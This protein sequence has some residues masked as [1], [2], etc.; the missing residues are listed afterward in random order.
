MCGC[1]EERRH[2]PRPCYSVLRG[3]RY[4]RSQADSDEARSV[5]CWPFGVTVPPAPWPLLIVLA[6]CDPATPRALYERSC[7]AGDLGPGPLHPPQVP[8]ASSRPLCVR[9]PLLVTAERGSPMLTSGFTVRSP[10][11][12]G[13]LRGLGLPGLPQTRVTYGLWGNRSLFLRDVRPGAQLL[14]HAAMARLG[15]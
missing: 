2:L 10:Q 6:S 7:T 4:T 11:D 3:T 13:G 14:G 1:E 8:G 15:W 12:I 5:A 9:S